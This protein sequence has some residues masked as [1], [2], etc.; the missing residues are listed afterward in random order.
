MSSDL[1]R[2]L[3]TLAAQQGSLRSR[4]AMWAGDDKLFSLGQSTDLLGIGGAHAESVFSEG[5]SDGYMSTSVL[6]PQL[7]TEPLLSRAEL[8]A[9]MGKDA[10][11]CAGG[12]T[13]VCDYAEGI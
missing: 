7:G 6:K 2:D 5:S 11:G 13:A 1:E 3:Q 4:K 9:A 10:N 8:E 12:R